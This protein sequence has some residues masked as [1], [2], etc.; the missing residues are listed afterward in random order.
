MEVV[1][2]AQG[3]E[4]RVIL[5]YTHQLKPGVMEVEDYAMKLAALAGLPALV[6]ERA[7]QLVPIVTSAIKVSRPTGKDRS[8]VGTSP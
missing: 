3:D 1:E 7:R 8:V 5:R 2:E 6:M 4:E